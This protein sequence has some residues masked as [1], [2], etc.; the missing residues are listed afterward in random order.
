M[1]ALSRRDWLRAAGAAGA[2]FPFLRP[3][4]ARA[5]RQ[6]NLVLLMQSNGTGQANFWPAPGTFTSPI[7][8]PI[9]GDAAL[10]PYAT[11][12]KGLINHDGGSGNGHVQGFTG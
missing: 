7:L 12:V 4:A 9:L 2:L 6:P 10:A 1:R 8:E 5:A 3:R 11:V